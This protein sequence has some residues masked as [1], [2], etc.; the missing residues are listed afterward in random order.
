MH[1]L[2][3]F[4][5]FVFRI[6]KRKVQLRNVTSWCKEWMSISYLAKHFLTG[7]LTLNQQI[8][9]ST[10][11]KCFTKGHIGCSFSI[12]S[13]VVE[14]DTQNLSMPFQKAQLPLLN[15]IKRL[16]TWLQKISF[17]N[18]LSFHKVKFDLQYAFLQSNIPFRMLRSLQKFH[19]LKCLF[20][21]S[22]LLFYRWFSQKIVHL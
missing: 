12:T 6:D 5:Q 15:D 18:N 9:M 20:N 19:I 2:V 3:L 14:Y 10:Y 8:P 13:G 21:M 7:T 16:F 4:I 11:T 17:H 1:V 22:L